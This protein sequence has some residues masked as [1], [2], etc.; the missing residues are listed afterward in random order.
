MS[1]S[2]TPEVVIVTG[3]GAGPGRSIAQA[4]ARRRAHIGLLGRDRDRLEEARREVEAAGGRALALPADVADAGQVEE[5]AARLEAALAPIDAWINNAMTSVLSPFKEMTAEEFRRVTDV[6]YLGYVHGT[7]AALRR[8]LPRDQGVI[9][10]VGSALAYRSI[11]LQAAYCGAKHAIVGFTDS[12]RSELIHD[13]SNVKLTAVHMPALNTPQ[14]SW[15]FSRLRRKPQPVPPIFQPEV[16]AEAVY[17]AA[18]HS[19]RELLVGWPTVQAVLGQKVIPGWIDRYLAR[20]AYEGQQYDG[21]A[22][23]R[24][25]TNLWEPVPGPYGAHGDFDRRA[26]SRSLQLWLATHRA[27]VALAGAGIA[28]LAGAAVAALRKGT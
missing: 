28:A 3:A 24:R 22:D 5:A 11:P 7:M 16:G 14:F 1:Q 20:V 17:W 21:L 10:Q 4:F 19:P 2:H 26:S 18:H 23:S 12:I 6:T 8:M 15:V 13:G 9:V 25:P 27:G